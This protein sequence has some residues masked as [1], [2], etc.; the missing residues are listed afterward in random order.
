MSGKKPAPSKSKKYPKRGKRTIGELKTHD[1]EKLAAYEA[2]RKALEEAGVILPVSAQLGPQ[3]AKKTPQNVAIILEHLAKGWS[4][5]VALSL[6]GVNR[7]TFMRWKEEDAELRAAVEE[8]VEAGTDFIEQE[9]RRRAVDGV[10]RPVFQQ[11]E[12]VGFVREYSD[13][14]M[15]QMLAGRRPEKYGKQRLEHSGPGGQPV[16]YD[17]QVSFVPAK[18]S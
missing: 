14:L 9:A 4:L 16:A 8:A 3:Q 7:R 1:P 10:D 13:T 17:V 6:I 15:T 11:G 12:C 18:Q 2:H 5:A